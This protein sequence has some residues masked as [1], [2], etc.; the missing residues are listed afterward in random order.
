MTKIHHQLVIFHIFDDCFRL[1]VH[2]Q[3][4]H[5]KWVGYFCKSSKLRKEEGGVKVAKKNTRQSL[6]FAHAGLRKLRN[7]VKLWNVDIT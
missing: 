6:H 7:W 1:D 2:L 5:K 3:R 4:D